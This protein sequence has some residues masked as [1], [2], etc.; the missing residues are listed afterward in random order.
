LEGLVFSHNDLLAN[1]VLIQKETH[2]FVFIDYE[3][4]SY[5]FPIFDLAN[6]IC[7]SEFNYDVNEPPYFA[8]TI[9]KPEDFHKQVRLIEAYVIGKELSHSDFRANF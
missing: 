4:A 1:N 9:L 3:Y 7:E 2:N 8:L 6:Y 5:N